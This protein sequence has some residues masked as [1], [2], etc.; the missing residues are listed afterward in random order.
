MSSRHR[1]TNITMWLHISL[2]VLCGFFILTKEAEIRSLHQ[3]ISSEVGTSV[4]LQC[5]FTGKASL[6]YWYKQPI[7]MKP[8]NMVTASKFDFLDFG[9][10]FKNNLRYNVS[11]TSNMFRLGISNIV[12]SDT[13]VYYCTHYTAGIMHFAEGSLLIVSGAQ[14]SNH[15]ILQK[16]ISAHVHQGESVDFQCAVHANVSNG[17]HTVY[18]FRHGSDPGIIYT[19]GN[20]SDQ[21]KK[22][23]ETVSPTQSC[24]YK[25]PKNNLSLSDAGTYYCAVAA[26]GEILFGDGTDLKVKEHH[27][28]NELLIYSLVATLAFF[29]ILSVVLL[30]IPVNKRKNICCQN[31]REL[32]SQPDNKP[33][34]SQDDVQ[35]D[36]EEGAYTPQYASLNFVKKKEAKGRKQRKHEETS[37]VVYSSVRYQNPN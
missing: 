30:V 15:A 11:R 14:T 25:L 4:T 32:S 1:R 10:E 21:C 31:C 37:V 28:E 35:G 6:L 2:I 16:P 7:G 36:R 27:K 12:P 33:S 5:S 13:A 26:C 17:N 3:I 23:S 8:I 9:E 18:W 29:I 22:S 34:V 24:I 20:R 19:H